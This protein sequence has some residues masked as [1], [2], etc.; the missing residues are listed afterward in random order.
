MLRLEQNWQQRLN[1]HYTRKAVDFK[2]SLK[3]LEVLVRNMSVRLNSSEVPL[4][5]VDK[6]K[7][8]NILYC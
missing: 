5:S 7:F 6:T 2:L 1:S 4:G 8:S 3:Q